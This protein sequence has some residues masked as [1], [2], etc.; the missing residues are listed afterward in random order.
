MSVYTIPALDILVPAVMKA[1]RRLH[2][3]P[4]LPANYA[5]LLGTYYDGSVQVEKTDQELVF[6][7]FD[8]KLKL[9]PITWPEIDNTTT[10][11]TYPNVLRAHPINSTAGCRWLDD[12]VDQE[13]VYFHLPPGGDAATYIEFMGDRFERK[14]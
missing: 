1:M 13:L 2:K 7:L 12:G 14:N 3:P 9:S 8:Q 11:T 4:P 10:T 5:R 6:H